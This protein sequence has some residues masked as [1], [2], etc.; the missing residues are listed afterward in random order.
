MIAPL[1]TI[2]FIPLFA[3]RNVLFKVQHKQR[4]E[5]EDKTFLLD[6]R[7]HHAMRSKVTQK[8]GIE[9]R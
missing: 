3:A 4:S 8:E 7:E 6:G 1:E 2:V 9:C 5:T